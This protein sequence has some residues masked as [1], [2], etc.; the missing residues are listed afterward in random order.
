MVRASTLLA[1]FA[2]IALIGSLGGVS[3]RPGNPHQRRGHPGHP[4]ATGELRPALRARGS[5]CPDLRLRGQTRRRHR[6]RLDLQGAG[7]RAAQRA[8]R[9]GGD[10]LRR[11]DL[12]GPGRQRRRRRSA[13]A[14][15]CAGCGSDPL[16]PA[17]GQG[18]RGQRSLLDDHAHPTTRHRRRG[19]PDRRLRRGSCRRG[20]AC[21]VRGNLRLLLPGHDRDAR[22]RHG[23]GADRLRHDSGIHVSSATEPDRGTGATRSGRAPGRLHA[24]GRSRDRPDV[25]HASRW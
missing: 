21:A 24:P 17:R 11:P 13:R 23:S 4:G 3:D 10:P 2:A 6:V 5:R 25:A 19:R 14:R 22:R 18:A 15:R 7:G 20:G 16:A 1:L 8:W 12:A 9:G